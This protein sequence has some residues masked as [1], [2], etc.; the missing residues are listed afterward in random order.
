MLTKICIK[1]T[2]REINTVDHLKHF[3]LRQISDDHGL[4]ILKICHKKCKEMKKRMKEL[5]KHTSLGYD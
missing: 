3:S 5:L 4:Q 1:E 2:Q